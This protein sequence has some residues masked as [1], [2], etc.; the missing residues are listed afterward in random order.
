M[1][2]IFRDLPPSEVD[3]DTYPVN[4]E[5]FSFAD[6][7]SVKAGWWLT[8][9][10]APTPDEQEITESVPYKQGSYDFSMI[11]NERFFDNREITYKLLYVGDEYKNRKGFEQ[12]LKR[13]LMPHNWGK[14]V[15]SH[16]PVY[17]WYAKCKSVEVDDDSESETLEASIV[18]T[19]YPF[20]YTN[21]NE[22][23]DYWDDVFFP[24]W[25][26]QPVKFTVNGNSTVNVK[27]IGSRPVL[28]GFNVTGNVKIKGGFGELSLDSSN[29]KNSQVVLDIGDN[30]IT[31]TG[32]GTIEFVFKREE[33]V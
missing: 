28:S 10:T 29:F 13:Q 26:W 3:L 1:E 17:Y 4:V 22:G 18:F 8:E 5:G 2:Y 23:A 21:H 30:N 19:A 9:R 33:M 6:F 24:H 11:D 16:E 12:E 31:L 27:N 20:A 7:D 32:N 15:D 14:L 25:I